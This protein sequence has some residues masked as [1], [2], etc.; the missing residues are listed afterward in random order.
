MAATDIFKFYL[1]HFYYVLIYG[2]LGIIKG[3]NLATILFIIG[4]TFILGTGV[5]VFNFTITIL[6]VKFSIQSRAS[7]IPFLAPTVVF[8][9]LFSWIR[10]LIISL[11]FG[12]K[13]LVWIVLVGSLVID[14]FSYFKI[15]G[16]IG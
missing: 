1:F 5:F 2:F 9:I 12:G 16:K 10:N 8:L 13:N 7:I 15:K 3:E 11:D 4:L 6:L 14:L